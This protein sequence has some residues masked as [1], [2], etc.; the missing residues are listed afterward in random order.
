MLNKLCILSLSILVGCASGHV[1]PRIG[2]E[3]P[4]SGIGATGNVTSTSSQVGFVGGLSFEGMFSRTWG[5]RGDPQIR[6]VGGDV[7]FAGTTASGDG[8]ISATGVITTNATF[9]D[10]PIMAMFSTTDSGST[11]HPFFCFGLV[12]SSTTSTTIGASGTQTYSEGGQS[13]SAP[14]A[15]QTSG[16]GGL[17]GPFVSALFSGGIRYPVS[18]SWEFRVEARLQHH[19]N[20]ADFASYTL[21]TASYRTVAR[22]TISAP[23]TSV[24]VTLG[25]MLRL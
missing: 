17:G 6:T 22:V 1:G 10:L 3:L 18:Q 12:L 25:M 13:V 4:V 2:A 23:T 15:S 11:I 20:E 19:L 14:F 5:L 8:I 16:T 7:G 24:G 21:Y 9:V